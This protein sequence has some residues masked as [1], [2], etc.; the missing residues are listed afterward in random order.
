MVETE[1]VVTPKASPIA[2]IDLLRL[3]AAC[4]VVGYHF[5]YFSWAEAAGDAGIRD[6][7][8][9][10]PPFH[11]ALGISWWGWIG[12]ELF[13]VISGF[14]IT[15]SA[16]GKTAVGFARGRLLR[17]YPALLV[18]SLAALAVVVF[19]DLLPAGEAIK[20]WVFAIFLFPKGPWIDGVV[21]T[22]TIEIIF[23]ALIFFIL[24]FRSEKHL[25]KFQRLWLLVVVVFWVLVMGHRTGLPLGSVGAAA[26]NFADAYM[27]RV[28]LLTTGPFFL[29]GM[30]A[31]ELHQRG[32]TRERLAMTLIAT[33]CGA[34]A[35]FVS[36]SRGEP[37]MH[38]GQLAWVP[39][40]VW[41]G[42]TGFCF[43]AIF[44]STLGSVFANHGRLIRSL[45]LM[46]Y[47][48]YLMHNMTGG[49]ILGRLIALGLNPW[50]AAAGAFV[51]CLAVSYAFAIS[52]EPLLRRFM[53][54]LWSW[55]EGLTTR[56][57]ASL[58][59]G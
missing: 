5:L 1:L 28:V 43:L 51:T 27:S 25:P 22:L 8:G 18:F 3:L 29:V 19:G 42:L 24:A 59:T 26:S 45:G 38:L 7:I 33:V 47:P 17:I 13:F 36:A 52:L 39:V 44:W 35:V 46:T 56:R 53:G 10:A 58:P 41:L 16:T 6:A 37:V 11:A 31:N 4:L 34:C 32:F 23:Y 54:R 49:W 40:L 48:L 57:R 14:V 15:L 2:G 12:V 21:W 30:F 55:V 50:V 20:R 9:V